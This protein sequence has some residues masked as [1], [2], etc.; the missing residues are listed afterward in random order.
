MTHKLSTLK[1]NSIEK[2]DGD[3]RNGQF[4]YE[5]KIEVGNGSVPG[6][7]KTIVRLADIKQKLKAKSNGTNKGEEKHL[8]TIF[9]N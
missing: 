3:N 7:I 6:G 1:A 5:N 8:N 9:L 2:K 4:L